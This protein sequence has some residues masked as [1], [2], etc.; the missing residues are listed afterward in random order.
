MRIVFGSLALVSF[1]IMLWQW[2]VAKRFPLHRRYRQNSL[3]APVTLLKPLKGMDE[4]TEACLRSWFEQDYPGEV[5]IIFGVA[6]AEDRVCDV[7]RK[8][9]NE[10]PDKDAQLRICGPLTGTNL[11]VSKL[12]EMETLAKHDLVVMSDADVRAPQ[13]LLAN[14]VQ[15]IWGSEAGLVHCLY[16]LEPPT[17]LAMRCEAV[18][19]NADF[20]SQ[21]LQSASLKPVDFGLGAVMMFR[22]ADLARIG[23]FEALKNCL[24]DDYQIGHRIAKLSRTIQFSTVVVECWSGPMHWRAV[25]QHQLRW[26]RTIRVSQPAPYFFS[27]L[28]NATL[29]SAVWIAV[30]PDLWAFVVGGMVL[31]A[32]AI[33][34]VKLQARLAQRSG[35]WR[36]FWVP[37][38][39]DLMQLGIWGL[40]FM[41]NSI[42]WRGKQMRLAPDGTLEPVRN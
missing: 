34:A 15:Q 19:V 1:G 6:S 26:A 14:M 29:W 25:W 16:R 22:R 17:N 12:A 18:S 8:L 38:V 13:D 4:Y 7:V 21:V 42:E 40:A 3:A 27:I 28:S 11:K 32:R 35:G 39:K 24:A 5:Q 23:G 37:W 2:L 41:G 9:I 31:G 30:C 20:W 10:F 33:F 36:W